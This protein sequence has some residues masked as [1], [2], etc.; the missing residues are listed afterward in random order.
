MRV[1]ADDIEHLVCTSIA[2]KLSNPEWVID[3]LCGA[4]TSPDERV[5]R[6]RR[7]DQLAQTLTAKEA[8]DHPSPDCRSCIAKLVHR[9]MFGDGIMTITLQTAAVMET[10]N[11][12]DAQIIDIDVPVRFHQAGRNKPILLQAADAP[13]RD[14]DLIALIGDARRWVRDLKS[15]KATSIKEMTKLEGHSDGA[16]SRVL[17]LAWLAPD[18]SAAIL[19]GRQPR[20]LTA[21]GLRKLETLPIDWNAQRKLLGFPTA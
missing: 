5:A 2:G 18:I 9:V 16:I 12:D 17:P 1:R 20:T 3:T 19:E 8:A 7:A 21:T 15:G 10:Q 11:S 6:S 4:G 14:P 13:Y